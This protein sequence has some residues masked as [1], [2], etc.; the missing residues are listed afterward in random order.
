MTDGIDLRGIET[1]NLKGIDVTLKKHAINL[2]VGPSGSGKSSLAYD[3]IAQIGQH[4]LSAMFADDVFEPTYR[5]ASYSNMVAAVPIRQSNQNNN[6]RSTIGT[7]FGVSRIIT[8]AFAAR[9]GMNEG[10]FTLNKEGNICEACH[11]MGTVRALD[12]SRIVDFDRP[13]YKNPIRCWSR[14]KDFYAQITQAFCDDMSIDAEKTFRQ[15]SEREGREFLYGESE[16]KYSIRYKRTGSY[17]QR[18]TKFYGIMT[19]RPMMVGFKVGDQYYRDVRCDRCGGKRYAPSLEE[20]RVGGMSIGDLM[21]TSLRE[22]GDK[23]GMIEGSGEHSADLFCLDRVRSF[24]AK[25]VELNLGHLCLNRSIPT[26]SGGE[27][28]RLRMVQVFCTQ[29]SDLLIVL[30]EPLAG[31]SGRERDAVRDNVRRLTAA[32]TLVVVDHSGAFVNDSENIIALGTGGGREGG[33]LVDAGAFL[34]EQRLMRSLKV[35]KPTSSLRL[36]VRSQVYDF[37]GCDLSI[38]TDCL[39]L[40]IGDS[41]VGKSTL[42]REYMPQVLEHYLYIDQKPIMGNK[43]SYVATALGVFDRITELFAKEHGRDKSFFSNQFGCEGACAK[44]NGAGYVEYG[45]GEAR[46]R[47]TCAE[48]GGTGFNR[49]LDKFALSSKTMLDVWDMT[50]DE[51]SVFLRPL[52]ARVADLLD[53]ASSILLGHLVIGQPSSTLSGG[54]NVRIKLLKAYRSSAKTIGLDEPFRG[55]DNRE[56]FHVARY[57]DLLRAHGKTIVAIDHTESARGY[58]ANCITLRNDRGILTSNQMAKA[59]VTSSSV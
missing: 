17:S 4:E 13:L 33:K 27:L 3:T 49:R 34:R 32:H 52:D 6:M 43:H 39:N 24:I 50:V 58:F 56:V 10:T 20:Y 40:I 16:S 37:G 51:A 8:R 23:V 53:M 22:L 46:V 28:Q 25:A 42:L 44:C 54:E 2:I 29:L 26:L 38:G 1:N 41:G 21:T 15:L 55:L 47:L 5:V 18:T 48:C 59:Y 36:K 14:Y 35:V 19:G 57:L 11:G 12:V 45:N 9:L 31:L 7:Y 30:D